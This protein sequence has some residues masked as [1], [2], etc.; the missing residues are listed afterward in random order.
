MKSFKDRVA[1]ITGAG[2]GIGRALA[3]ELSAAGCKLAL[4]DIN[5]AAVKA[6]AA[7]L[8]EKGREVMVDR[9]DVADREACYAYASK[10]MAHYGKG[11]LVFTNAGVA[12]GATV[13]EMSYEDC[14]CRMGINFSGVV[15][16][17]KAF[18][19]YFKQSVEGHII[20]V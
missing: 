8:K 1:V 14:E 17:T 19:P 6:V 10:V 15:Y 4:S 7:E 11:N 9:L 18:P 5:E 12:V 2:S 16:A 3:F 13:E 20:N